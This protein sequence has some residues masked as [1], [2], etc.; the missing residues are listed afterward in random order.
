MQNKTLDWVFANVTSDVKR[1]VTALKV[2]TFYCGR[3]FSFWPS[4]TDFQGLQ[5]HLQSS[6]QSP[7]IPAGLTRRAGC[8]REGLEETAAS[9][10][11]VTVAAMNFS[12]PAIHSSALL[13]QICGSNLP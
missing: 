9:G 3:Y 5:H 7:F 10:C 1:F 13:V 2:E 4:A 11:G 6:L 8:G 12:K